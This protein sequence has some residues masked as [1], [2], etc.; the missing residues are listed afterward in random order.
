MTSDSPS[1]PQQLAAKLARTSSGPTSS[2]IAAVP[3]ALG[4]D[5]PVE[6]L[7]D[8]FSRLPV[9]SLL[10]FR[11]VS[12]LW[13]CLIGETCL[14]GPHFSRS[15]RNVLHH[16][17]LITAYSVEKSKLTILSGDT[18]S[19]GGPPACLFCFSNCR[20]Q[21]TLFGRIKGFAW[22]PHRDRFIRREEFRYLFN[23]STRQILE[24]PLNTLTWDINLCLYALGF[25]RNRE[26]FKV[27]SINISD[28]YECHILTI[29]MSGIGEWKKVNSLMPFDIKNEFCSIRYQDCVCVAGVMHWI[30]WKVKKIATFNLETESFSTM[31]LPVELQA[32]GANVRTFYLLEIDGCLAVVC[33]GDIPEFGSC[34]IDLWILKE[35]ES[36]N[37][38]GDIINLPV[39]YMGAYL[40]GSIPYSGEIVLATQRRSA[41]SAIVPLYDRITKSFREV[42]IP[43]PPS[44]SSYDVKLGDAMVYTESLFSFRFLFISLD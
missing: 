20:F 23:P 6:I 14:V 17:F 7:L 9:K 30:L 22:H 5:L 11:S 26:E 18:R 21:Q 15:L 36:G 1:I 41:D 12:K 35:Y 37:W 19:G 8:I 27:L 13:R 38:I 3:A 32:F 33:D 29:R 31:E 40:T 43:L 10:R 16:H 44:L 28:G 42:E 24:I 4:D 39:Y 2:K 25:S 34:R